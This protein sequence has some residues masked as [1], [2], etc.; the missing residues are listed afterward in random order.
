[1]HDLARFRNAQDRPGAGFEVALGEIRAGGKRSHWIWYIFPQLAGL[2][3]SPAAQAYA[4]QGLDEAI[5]YLRDPVLCE[6]LVAMTRAVSDQMAAG[7]LRLDTLMGS[8]IDALKLVSSLTLFGSVAKALFEDEGFEAHGEL[9]RLAGS[10]L[11][12]AA[13]DGYPSCSFTRDRLTRAGRR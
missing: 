4:I 3:S 11:A 1:V 6:R 7:R 2:G 5:A 10:V 12:A 13:A 8:Q 9:A